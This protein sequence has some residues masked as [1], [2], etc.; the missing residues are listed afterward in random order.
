MNFN[1]FR[2][3]IFLG[4]AMAV[5]ACNEAPKRFQ[6]L[7]P[8]ES[9][10][11]F[12]NELKPT[13]DLN[14]LTYLY[15][16][17]GAGVAVA[18]Y[19][20]D[21]L[22]DLYFTSNQG[23]DKL[24]LNQ[25]NLKF[26]DVT[27]AAGIENASGWTTGVTHVDINGDGLLDIYVCKVG[28]YKTIAGYNLL[29]VNQGNNADGI[30]VFKESAAN[31]G[32]DLVAFST[33]AAF[34]D[35]DLDGDLDLYLMSH[36]VHPNHSY[37]KGSTRHNV[38]SL[39]GDRLFENVEGSF[40]NVSEYAGIFQAKIGYGLGLSIGDLNQDG[41]PDIYVGNDFFE[42]DYLYQNNGD[43]T[44]T[45]LNST[46]LKVLGHTTHYSMG[47]SIVDINND[48]RSDIMSLDMLPED[49]KTLKS[50]GVED[51]YPIYNT[52]L[53]NGYAPQYMQN[54]LHLNRG[55]GIYSEVG[56][57][58]GIAA[59]EW[60]WG[61]LAA[62][63]DLDGFKDIYIT[64]GILGATNDMDYINFVSQDL[65]QQSIGQNFQGQSLDFAK[66]IP[67]K[68]VRNYMFQNVGGTAFKEVSGDWFDAMPSLSNGGA[69]A[70]LDNDGD[71]DIVVNNVNEAA[72][73]F[74]NLSREQDDVNYLTVGFKGGRENVFGIGAKVEVFAKDLYVFEENFPV[75]SYLSAIPNEM[76]IGLGRSNV[77]D[78]IKVTWP[79]G[80]QQIVR[81]INGNQKI[82]FDFSKAELPS[83]L[84]INR[85]AN[86]FIS[87]ADVSLEFKHREESTLDF[88]RNPLVP[89]ALSN[90][91]PGI[92][93]GDINGDSLDDI[94]V[95]GAKLQPSQ[96]FIQS[97]DGTFINT[98]PEVWESAA[99]S[100][101]VDH[102]FFDAD[103]DSDLD[104][105]VVSG[106]NEFVNGEPLKPRLYINNAGQFRYV[107]E[108]FTDI[109]INASVVKVFDFDKDGDKDVV[110]GSNALPRE[111][112]A[113]ARNF[114]FTN[115]GRGRFTDVTESVGF[116]FRDAGLITALEIADLDG[117]GYDDIIAVGT[118]MP[119]TVFMNNGSTVSSRT[120]PNSEGWWNCVVA[121]DFDK[122]GDI[123]LIA[124]NWGNN[125]RLKASD[126]QPITL[127]RDDFDGNGNTETLI[128]YYYRGQQTFLSSMDGLAKQM[129]FIRKKYLSY[130]DFA[131]ASV[132]E[133]IGADKLSKAMQKQTKT[134]LT[135]YFRNEGDGNFK[136]IELPPA[137]QQSTVNAIAI[138]DF[139]HDGYHDIL[140]VGNNYEIS[141]QL[142]RLDASHGVLLL[143]DRSGFFVEDKEQSFNVAG[144]ARNVKKIKIKGGDYYVVAMNNDKPIFLKKEEKQ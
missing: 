58:S 136:P 142:G 40:V 19:N 13:E 126:N 97:R 11:D 38:D 110:I 67:E 33:Q 31:Y 63:Y 14:I 57:Q 79:G 123:D 112:G 124:G 103:N 68:R 66:Y 53:E 22:S 99:L 121:E 77:I 71:L 102:V 26:K 52:F 106:G 101:D 109:A 89:F 143:N 34:F 12:V 16:Y 125:S 111:F 2:Y 91:G 140:L 3:F 73:V 5:S 62:D 130:H 144:A 82:H 113:D 32:L 60:S 36:S 55:N 37:G 104:L 92:S 24:Y 46:D 108:E 116:A 21:G 122:D 43:K 119:I 139:N 23:P 75:K 8:S 64:N 47:N 128:T 18:D 115:D 90:E 100:E 17:N 129:P 45:E 42:N 9:G 6:A 87:N 80:R 118:W 134:L 25:G 78:S 76:V 120:I 88:D 138:D 94:F 20:Q 107:K 132:D 48:G 131:N 35:Y 10:V 27:V 93:I 56:F 70:D 114:I 74:Q 51:E 30:P 50:S 85:K 83:T 28:K 127:Y 59:T 96:L 105:L 1:L 49:L 81:N 86:Q 98:Q 117:N 29:F 61:I 44:F 72:F 135:T 137:A 41:Y 54:T 141:T 4:L 15:Y 39:A 65:I 95:S 69:Y 84:E 133:V 7:K